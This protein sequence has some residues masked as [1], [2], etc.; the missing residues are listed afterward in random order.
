MKGSHGRVLRP[1]TRVG[2]LERAASDHHGDE[3]PV[4][5]CF[6]GLGQAFVVTCVHAP[7]DR[8][9]D[10]STAVQDDEVLG[11]FGPGDAQVEPEAFA[12]PVHEFPGLA[13]VGPDL[14]D[15]RPSVAQAP[16]HVAGGVA[17]W[18]SAGVTVIIT[19]RPSE[20]TVMC[21]L[22]PLIFWP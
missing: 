21:H 8:A 3:R 10:F 2:R 14:G 7:A 19:G 9:L 12:G 6:A 20:S 22:R 18:M 4:Q 1:L 17:V 13:A 11:A 16:E 15:L 5:V